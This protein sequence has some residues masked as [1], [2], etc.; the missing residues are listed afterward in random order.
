[1]SEAIEKEASRSFRMKREPHDPVGKNPAET[2]QP[3]AGVETNQLS[4][5][6]KKI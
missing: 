2:K 6:K 5:Q 1:M 4:P 3:L